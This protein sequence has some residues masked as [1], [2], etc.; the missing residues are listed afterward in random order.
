MQ[1]KMLA[2]CAV[3]L[4]LAIEMTCVVTAQEAEPELTHA[5]LLHGFMP[6]SKQEVERVQTANLSPLF[7]KDGDVFVDNAD[8]VRMAQFKN[9]HTV[10]ITGGKIEESGFRALMSLR[11]LN[12]L[13]LSDCKFDE[14]DLKLLAASKVV[15]LWIIDCNLSDEGVAHLATSKSIRSLNLSGKS[16]T[17]KSVAH[18]SQM[19]LSRLEL[20]GT[21]IDDGAVADL[22][23]MTLLSSLDLSST[24]IT[25]ASMPAIA[26]MEHLR[27]V[28]LFDTQVTKSGRD[29]LRQ[30]RRHLYLYVFP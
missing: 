21:D 4:L 10:T 18:I 30:L 28:N 27:E 17:N 22:A 9:V 12:N 1:N 7:E 29:D 26:K 2:A 8:V 5:A 13:F 19:I 15:S 20:I 24:K 16:I 11:K 6:P 23:K 14:K 3:G 25:D